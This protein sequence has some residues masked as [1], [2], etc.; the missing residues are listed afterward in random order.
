MEKIASMKGFADDGLQISEF[1]ISALEPKI[2]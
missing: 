1:K 2:N